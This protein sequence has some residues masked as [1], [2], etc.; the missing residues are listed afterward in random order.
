M[1]TVFARALLYV[2][3]LVVAIAAV[4]GS[5]SH[6]DAVPGDGLPAPEARWRTTWVQVVV[7]RYAEDV[8]W[9]ANLP[10]QDIVVYDKFDKAA[11]EEAEAEAEADA[12]PETDPEEPEPETEAEAVV[13]SD[14]PVVLF[15][16][17]RPKKRRSTQPRR[18]RQRQPSALTDD[19][20]NPP[21]SARVERLPNVGRCDHTYLHHIVH[22]WDRLADVTIFVP[23]SC[24]TSRSK[25]NKLQWIVS[26][27]GRTGDSAFPVDLQTDDPV[28]M[29]LGDFMLN[30][31][32][33]SAPSNAAVNPETSLQLCKHRPFGI[34]YYAAFPE[35]PP[36]HE[37]VYQGVFAVSRRHIQ[38]HG[39]ERY[40]RL[41]AY[42][43]THSNPE[44][45]HYMERSW[46]AAFYPVPRDCMSLPVN[47]RELERKQAVFVAALVAALWMTWAMAPAR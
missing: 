36:V 14:G 12:D 10:F 30:S 15:A 19:H 3:L 24:A 2:V 33:A 43:D 4:A 29:Q 44:A 17:P 18:R 35:L 9:L 46:L 22:G 34:F 31:Y 7:A 25:W 23:G 38:Q 21:P 28:Y 11:A 40:E 42:L 37:V 45:G 13:D 6:R 8:S 47:E 5:P 27:V 20:G 41:L 32:Q 16:P 39:R 1:A 26:Q